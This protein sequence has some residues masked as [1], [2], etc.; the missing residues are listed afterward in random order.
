M[1][2]KCAYTYQAF[3]SLLFK[4]VQK[5]RER[6]LLKNT[7]FQMPFQALVLVALASFFSSLYEG[8]VFTSAGMYY[9]SLFVRTVYRIG[10]TINRELIASTFVLEC[11][12]RGFCRIFSKKEVWKKALLGC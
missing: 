3:T 8:Q 2:I 12:P 6:E 7:V 10:G 11:L 5:N 1:N 4:T 9:R